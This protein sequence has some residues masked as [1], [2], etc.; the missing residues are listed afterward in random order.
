MKVIILGVRL[1]IIIQFNWD[2]DTVFPIKL[3]YILMMLFRNK[4]NQLWSEI[5]ME[6]VQLI[7]TIDLPILFF[8]WPMHVSVVYLGEFF[9]LAFCPFWSIIALTWRV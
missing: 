7:I 4:T 5:A 9:T 8:D 2:S 6:I 1:D 3:K